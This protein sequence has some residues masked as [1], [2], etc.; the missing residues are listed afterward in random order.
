MTHRQRIAIP[1]S[2]RRLDG[3][4]ERDPEWGALASH[5]EGVDV[6]ELQEG[7]VVKGRGR[8]GKQEEGNAE[9]AQNNAAS[10]RAAC[11][12]G[13]WDGAWRG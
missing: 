5:A 4:S 10:L 7:V 1:S 3:S 12:A 13:P 8:E 6:E 2:A 11:R 9:D